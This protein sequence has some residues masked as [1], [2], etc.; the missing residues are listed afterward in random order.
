MVLTRKNKYANNEGGESYVILFLPQDRR[1]RHG[2]YTYGLEKKS[3]K[4]TTKKTMIF[5]HD[6]FYSTQR[7]DSFSAYAEGTV[8]GTA[9]CKS[10]N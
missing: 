1:V 10:S 2:I 7:S 4:L 5:Q 8:S 9:A 6:Y 3:P